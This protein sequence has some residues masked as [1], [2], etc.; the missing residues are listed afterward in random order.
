MLIMTM[1]VGSSQC[2][3][4]KVSDICN[5]YFSLGIVYN[6]LM[7]KLIKRIIDM[8]KILGCGRND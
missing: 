4:R 1:A 2:F 3:L 5:K 8:R 7:D 6:I